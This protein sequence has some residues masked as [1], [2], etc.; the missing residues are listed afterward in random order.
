MDGASGA[1]GDALAAHLA[2]VEVDVGEVVFDLDSAEGANFLALAAADAGGGAGLASDSAFLLVAAG[3]EDAVVLGAFVAELD[4][5]TR[6]SLDAGAAGDAL[7]GIDDGEAGGR[8]D[9]EGVELASLG[10]VAEAEAAEGAARLASVEAI[11]EGAVLEA[12]EMVLGG[13]VATGAVAT[14]DGDLRSASLG[15]AAEEGSDFLSDLIATSGALETIHVSLFDKSFCHGTATSLTATAAVGAWEHIT[16]FVDERIL[17]DLELLSHK[18]E[19]NCEN[20][21]G[22]A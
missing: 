19:H 21:A 17:F 2:E 7:V 6:A 10:A 20:S 13:G 14:D 12:V 16:D 8:V 5:A 15:D 1:V 22:D 3:D 4:D 11:G 9:A 18:I